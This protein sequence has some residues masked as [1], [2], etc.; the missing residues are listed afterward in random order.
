MRAI[1]DFVLILCIA[2]TLVATLFVFYGVA[3]VNPYLPLV[4]DWWFWLVAVFMAL[5]GVL[6]ASSL[7][8]PWRALLGFT[9]FGT[10]VTPLVKALCIDPA[11]PIGHARLKTSA[12]TTLADYLTSRLQG[13]VLIC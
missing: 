7:H 2:A 12:P 5:P 10:A 3:F 13:G 4:V 8:S 11:G 6:L 9:L 1:Y